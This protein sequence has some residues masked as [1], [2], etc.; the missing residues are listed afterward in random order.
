MLP[1]NH[2]SDALPVV[3]HAGEYEVHV[4]EWFPHCG[5]GN[6][7]ACPRVEIALLG[8]TAL[9]GTAC[10]LSEFSGLVS[11]RHASYGGWQELCACAPGVI[12]CMHACS[13]FV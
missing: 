12:Q 8:C 9:N 7:S 5:N 4:F 1:N 3:V 11:A 13:V 2:G 6:M 10:T